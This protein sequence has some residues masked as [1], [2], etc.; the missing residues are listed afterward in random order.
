MERRSFRSRGLRRPEDRG[1]VGRFVVLG[2]MLGKLWGWGMRNCFRGLGTGTRRLG[3][4]GNLPLG[5]KLK[6]F[7]ILSLGSGSCTR[8]MK[9]L[10]ESKQYA[11]VGTFEG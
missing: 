9:V 8:C 5:G 6:S 1:F 4:S 2:R 10:W 3:P 11:A 7:D